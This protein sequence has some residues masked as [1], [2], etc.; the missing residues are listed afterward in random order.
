MLLGCVSQCSCASPLPG[1]PVQ[2]QVWGLAS[3]RSPGD[4]YIAGV[5]TALRLVSPEDTGVFEKP[6][7]SKWVLFPLEALDLSSRHEKVSR[8][9]GE[10]GPLG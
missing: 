4:T 10:E 5:W 3:P 8:T 7:T 1:D 2:V 6:N 9:Q